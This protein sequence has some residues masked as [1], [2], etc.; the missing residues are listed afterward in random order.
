MQL[1]KNNFTFFSDSDF[2]A[3]IR[4][5][6]YS[7]GGDFLCNLAWTGGI[8]LGTLTTADAGGGLFPFPPLLSFSEGVLDDFRVRVFWF[9]LA[10]WSA[11]R[12]LFSS[13]EPE[14]ELFDE[15]M[16]SVLVFPWTRGLGFGLLA[17]KEASEAG[18]SITRSGVCFCFCCMATRW[19]QKSLLDLNPPLRLPASCCA[20]AG[21]PR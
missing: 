17:A 5:V 19:F 15:D 1:P 10:N 13:P 9:V 20:V 12:L 21:P 18:R 7:L 11:A 8:F 2:H 4:I 3:N 16:E 14:P 6:F